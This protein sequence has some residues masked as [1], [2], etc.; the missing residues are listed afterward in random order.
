MQI[1]TDAI[2]DDFYNDIGIEREQL[3]QI[4]SSTV[5]YLLFFQ[6]YKY[7]ELKISKK[8]NKQLFSKANFVLNFDKLKV[9]CNS[10]DEISYIKFVENFAFDYKNNDIENISNEKM[11]CFDND[12]FILSLQD[13]VQ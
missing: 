10:I 9:V 3:Y 1:I 4:V 2:D 6:T 13:F 8:V 11:F 5:L 12:F 7:G